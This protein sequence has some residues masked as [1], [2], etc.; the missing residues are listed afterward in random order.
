MK[1]IVISNNG[2]NYLVKLDNKQYVECKIKGNFRLKGIRSTNPIAIGDNVM[3]QVNEKGHS[4]IYEICDRKN[5]I[6]RKSSNLSKHS[7]ILAANVDQAFLLITINYPETSTTFIDRFLT[8]AEAYQIPVILVFNKIDL[9]TDE[10]IDYLNAITNLYS[11]LGY[12]CIHT[13][14]VTNIGV[15]QIKQRI[16]QKISILS[17]NSGVGKS[18]LIKLI[19][20]SFEVKIGAISDVHNKG[21]HT[22]TNSYMY[23]ISDG[24]IIDTPGIKGFGVIN[25]S[26]NEIAHYFRDIFAFSKKCRYTNCL[27]QNEP[28]C[29]VIEA[30]DTHLISSSRYHSYLSILSEISEIE[31]YR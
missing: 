25:I 19:D 13:S 22:T 3:V 23:E 24:Y 16:N 30:V 26:K 5:Y 11:Q 15:E 20:T 4:Y 8:S 6:I 21:V 12:E 7:H 14:L 29:A 31:K 2:N 17:G 18:S 28:G 1:G 10:E 27:H 9:Y